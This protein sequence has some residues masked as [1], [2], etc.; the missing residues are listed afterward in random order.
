MMINDK[1]CPNKIVYRATS[2]FY[3][4][5]TSFFRPSLVEVAPPF[6]GNPVWTDIVPPTV[7]PS[8]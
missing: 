3:K 6:M 5:T 1:A 8:P 7:G 4:C 2:T